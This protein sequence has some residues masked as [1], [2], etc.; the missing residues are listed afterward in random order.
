[1]GKRMRKEK[2]DR[3]CF[4]L[5]NNKM[6]K[7]GKEQGEIDNLITEITMENWSEHSAEAKCEEE[8]E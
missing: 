7:C 3:Q 5:K 2:N 8:G 4:I 1:M 6:Q